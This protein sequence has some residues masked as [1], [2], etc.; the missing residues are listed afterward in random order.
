MMSMGFYTVL[1]MLITLVIR[2]ILQQYPLSLSFDADS[3]LG[4][5]VAYQVTMWGVI[6]AQ[7][8]MVQEM[9]GFSGL[10]LTAIMGVIVAAVWYM[11]R[12]HGISVAVLD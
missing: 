1:V 8:F 6:E 4:V 5:V 12:H 11:R 7:L 10:H 2:E 9:L 3:I